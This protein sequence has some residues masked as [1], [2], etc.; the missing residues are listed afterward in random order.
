MIII[1]VDDSDRRDD[2][3]GGKGCSEKRTVVVVEDQSSKWQVAL[4]PL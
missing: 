2:V 3:E 1:Q 4:K